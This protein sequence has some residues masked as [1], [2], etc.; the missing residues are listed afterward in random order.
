MCH[1]NRLSVDT[2]A[3]STSVYPHHVLFFRHSPVVR[4]GICYGQSHQATQHNASTVAHLYSKA[5]TSWRA[6]YESLHPTYIQ[7]NQVQLWSSP[8]PRCYEPARC[9]SEQLNFKLNVDQRILEMNFGAWENR[10]WEEIEREDHLRLHHWMNH[11]KTDSPPQGES[12]EVFQSRVAEW[13]SELCPH[14]LHILIGHAGVLRA[15][16]VIERIKT[17]DEAMSMSIPHLELIPFL[18]SHLI[19]QDDS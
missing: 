10:S 15:L 1:L 8:A 9:I 3:L 17:W 16:N 6:Q 19:S 18:S 5:Y 2:N 12:L 7:N 4:K 11:W 13:R 14:T